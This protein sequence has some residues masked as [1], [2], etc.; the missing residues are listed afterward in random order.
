LPP[1]VDLPPGCLEM[2]PSTYAKTL[3]RVRRLG[4]PIEY[5]GEPDP[6]TTE[7]VSAAIA[8]GVQS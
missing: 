4:D 8:R 1:V 6:T 5:N 7:E 2:A 3:K